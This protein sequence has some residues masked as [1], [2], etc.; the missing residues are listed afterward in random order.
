MYILYLKTST[1]LKFYEDASFLPN[2]YAVGH[3]CRIDNFN[4]LK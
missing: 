4:Q 2:D 1:P 3:S